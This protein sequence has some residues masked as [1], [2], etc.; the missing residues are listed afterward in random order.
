MTMHFWLEFLCLLS[1]YRGVR[2]S[3][4]FAGARDSWAN[5]WSFFAPTFFAKKV[6]A[7]KV[8]YSMP[9]TCQTPSVRVR[10]MTPVYCW[11]SS[12]SGPA[13]TVYSYRHWLSSPVSAACRSTSWATTSVDGQA[14]S[15]RLNTRLDSTASSASGLSLSPTR[16]V[17]SAIP[18]RFRFPY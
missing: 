15:T 1:L 12:P 18:P 5:G 11:G 9:V 8:G 3:H 17:S 7:K 4:P 2:A 13:V 6:G 16:S 14:M 10:D